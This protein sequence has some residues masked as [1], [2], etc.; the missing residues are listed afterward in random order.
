MVPYYSDSY[1][2][3]FALFLIMWEEEHGCTWGL[4]KGFRPPKLELQ[5][6]VSCSRGAALAGN[7]H[8]ISPAPYYILICIFLVTNDAKPVFVDS[9]II[10]MSFSEH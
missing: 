8:P 4:E 1:D 9:L 3:R 2:F 7:R 6:I 5:V 10:C